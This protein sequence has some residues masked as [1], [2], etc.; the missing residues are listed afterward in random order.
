MTSVSSRPVARLSSPGDIVATVPSLCGFLPQDSL[1][2]LSLRGPRRRLGLTVRVDLPPPSMASV[3]VAALVDRVVQDGGTAAVLV[4]YAASPDPALAQAVQD[5]C[6]AAGVDVAESLHVADGRWTSYACTAP[7]CPPAGTPVGAAPALVQAEHALDGRSVLASRD[8]LVRALDP[9]AEPVDLAEVGASWAATDPFAA[10]TRAL[11][12]A[13]E[14]LGQVAVP[15]ASSTAAVLGVAL[16]DVRVRDELATWALD[17][18]DALLALL[19]QV[20]RQVGPPWDAPV[21][22][23]LAWVAYCRGDGARA[24]VALDRALGTDPS[25]SLALLLRSALDGALPPAD[26]RRLL[27]ETARALRR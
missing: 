7:C 1:V 3:T 17:D 15:L 23:V 4:V 5:R 12:L 24:N 8:D 6:A 25:Y 26:V 11:A 27:R 2:L 21:C 13:R 18:S 9:P 10:R 20:A 22:T 16:H 19:H 14:A